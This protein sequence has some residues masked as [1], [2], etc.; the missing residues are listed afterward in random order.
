MTI[1][2]TVILSAA[3]NLSS[4]IGNHQRLTYVKEVVYFPQGNGDVQAG[5]DM[6]ENI[7]TVTSK[8]QVTIP[9]G[10]R[11]YLGIKTNDEVAFVI[12]DAGAVRLRVLRDPTVASLRGAAGSLKKPL[13]WQEMQRIAL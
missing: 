2:A 1:R 11:K 12:D 4:R 9:A 3:K 5:N 6:K 8:S 7:A 10:I 13:S